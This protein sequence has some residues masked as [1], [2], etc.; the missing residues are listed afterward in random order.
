M[1]DSDDDVIASPVGREVAPFE[2]D[3]HQEQEHASPTTGRRERKPLNPELF[4]KFADSV[5]KHLSDDDDE[6]A[7]LGVP[8]TAAKVEPPPEAK[9]PEPAKTPERPAGPP[10]EAIA[11][12]ER[13]NLLRADVEKRESTLKEREERARDV[14][15]QFAADPWAAL[16]SIA[17]N[18]LGDE[19]TES[20]VNDEL[21]YLITELSL[22]LAGAEVGNGNQAHELRKLKRE[23]THQKA[24]ARKAGALTAKQRAEQERAEREG[25]V[26]RRLRD[27]FAPMAPKFPWL[28][29]NEDPAGLLFDVIKR[30]HDKSGRVLELDEAAKL[31]DDYLSEADKSWFEKRKNL[32]APPPPAPT[33][34]ADVHQGDPPKRSRTLTNADASDDAPPVSMDELG[35]P[36]SVEERRRRSFE[37]W[38]A[39][40]A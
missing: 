24:Q 3:S 19:A 1:T 2:D 20:D 22:R 23:L 8:E 37:R 16:T 32:L 14:A 39:K 29:A 31:A 10:A 34:P 18:T 6:V 12:W 40:T 33:A 25:A 15:E 28:A 38:R 21:T 4:A 11:A 26:V 5:R 35:R 13:V 9:A 17:K 30:E 36:P 7:P 27:E